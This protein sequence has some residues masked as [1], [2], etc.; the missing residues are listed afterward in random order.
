MIT[1]RRFVQLGAVA[2]MSAAVPWSR[3]LRIAHGATQGP[4]LSDPAL[5]PKFVEA[6]P[7]ALDPG[8]IYDTSTGKIAVAA[9]Q[10]VQQT[11]LVNTN[12]MPVST[13]VWGYGDSQ[14]FTWPGRTFEVRSDEPLEV[15]W[16]SA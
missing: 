4:G 2:G 5:Q 16:Q 13:T 6:V 9:G 1:R 3:F 15:E 11:G 14:F 7:N 8:F 12:G 10:T